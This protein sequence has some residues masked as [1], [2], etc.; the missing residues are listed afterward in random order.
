M[1]YMR[2]YSWEG[3]CLHNGKEQTLYAQEPGAARHIRYSAVLPVRMEYF[4][5]IIQAERLAHEKVTFYCI[6]AA[7]VVHRFISE[8]D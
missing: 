1:I 4:Y 2:S 6:Q 8:A 3:R 7:F 5:V